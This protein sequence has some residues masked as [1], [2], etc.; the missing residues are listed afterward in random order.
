M[1]RVVTLCLLFIAVN[2]QEIKHQGNDIV[3]TSLQDIIFTGQ[4]DGDDISMKDVVKAIRDLQSS[5]DD[6]KATLKDYKNETETLYALKS[7]L[8]SELEVTAEL[9][10]KQVSDTFGETQ[11]AVIANVSDVQNDLESMGS[12]SGVVIDLEKDVNVIIQTL[13]NITECHSNGTLHAGDGKCIAAETLCAMPT[14]PANGDVSLLGHAIEALVGTGATFTCNTGYYM[15]GSASAVCLSSRQYSQPA[16]TCEKCSLSNCIACDSATKCTDCE[17]GFILNSGKCVQANAIYIL[18]GMHEGYNTWE[19]IEIA[20]DGTYQKWELQLPPLP[21]GATRLDK[22]NAVGYYKDSLIMSGGQLGTNAVF[23]FTTK[24]WEKITSPPVNSIWPYHGIIGSSLYCFG[25][26]DNSLTAAYDLDKSQWNIL[27]KPMPTARYRG[28]SAILNDELWTIG[29]GGP[30]GVSKVVEIYNPA[31]DEWRTGPEL[32]EQ[33]F[34]QACATLGNNIFC[35]GGRSANGV[36]I[37]THLLVMD[38]TKWVRKADMKQGR[39]EFG[40]AA[41]FGKIWAI[42]T[43]SFTDPSF[44]EI[45]D[46]VSDSWV[47]G[48]SMNR[49]RGVAPVTVGIAM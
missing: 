20:K 7:E 2:G 33:R 25:G 37:N 9:V 30:G 3:I 43:Y 16:P 46:P 8:F 6:V 15:K 32:P 34:D 31:K 4:D 18:G 12:L 42:G 41:I 13:N 27:K 48:P 14:K 40:A 10:L 22:G 45:Y 17:R 38:G 28:G 47:D 36:A 24:K 29:G 23:S 49:K 44:T 35:M 19:S 21:F 5:M 1:M 26:T 39:A 11:K